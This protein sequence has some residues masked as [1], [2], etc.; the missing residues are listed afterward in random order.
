LYF[1]IPKFSPTMK[2]NIPEK[3]LLDL[4]NIEKKN[5]EQAIKENGR[6]EEVK[7][8]YL[9]V[10]KLEQGAQ[11]LTASKDSDDYYLTNE[12]N[13]RKLKQNFI[14][15]S[16]KYNAALNR[17]SLE[18]IMDIT[19]F[20]ELASLRQQTV[21]ASANLSNFILESVKRIHLKSK[22]VY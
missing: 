5:Y 12:I 15:K 21:L 18:D 7:S 11:T 3:L 4:I 20:N 2:E 6:F 13:Y 16:E 14:S 8:L 19:Q 1:Y 22:I 9:K 10:K 17:L